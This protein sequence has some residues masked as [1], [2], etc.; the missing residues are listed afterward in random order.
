MCIES[1]YA[2]NCFSTGG[3]IA[4]A[5]GVKNWSVD[6][7]ISHFVKLCDQA[8]TPRELHKVPGLQ[9]VSALHHGSSYKTQPLHNALQEELGSEFLFGGPRNSDSTSTTKVAVTATDEAGKKAIIFANYRYSS[10]NNPSYESYQPSNPE[11]EMKV[12]EA[13]AATSAAPSYFK[14][15]YHKVAGRCYL[16]GALYNNNPVRVAHRE[17]R[18]LWPDVLSKDPDIFLS[19]GTGQSEKYAKNS[20]ETFSQ[21]VRD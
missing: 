10:S 20:L 12:W 11:L 18:M 1:L 21:Y 16:D 2:S 6:K 15:F 3:I 14:P 4:L 19:I 13:A 7:C 9:K 8:F 17:R 5:L